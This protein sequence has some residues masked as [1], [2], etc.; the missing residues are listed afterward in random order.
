M[1]G[2]EEEQTMKH[3]LVCPLPPPRTLYPKDL[4]GFNS[5]ATS[6]GPGLCGGLRGRTLL[7]YLQK[8]TVKTRPDNYQIFLLFS[9]RFYP[10]FPDF[11]FIFP[12][13]PLFFPNFLSQ[14]WLRIFFFFFFFLV[15]TITPEK[16]K[17]TPHKTFAYTCTVVGFTAR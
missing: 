5:K 9:P 10:L 13:S 1:C 2:C 3:L 7:V 4:E 16:Q 17:I 15:L 11:P 12:F 14:K 6:T 8:N